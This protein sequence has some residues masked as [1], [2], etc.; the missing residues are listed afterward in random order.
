MVHD[1]R[2]GND[3][4]VE[5]PKKKT[6]AQKEV[7][8]AA[9]AAR[10]TDDQATGR[11]HTF[12]IQEPR[13]RTEEQQG[14]PVGLSPHRSLHVRSRTRGGH[15]EHQGQHLSQR[16]TRARHSRTIA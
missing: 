10:V 7:D 12:Q 8:R 11:G 4:V 1:K 16:E 2:K 3:L 14:D 9:M 13:G 6:R 15:T 5:P